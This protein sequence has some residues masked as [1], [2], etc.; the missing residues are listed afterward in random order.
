MTEEKVKPKKSDRYELTQVPTEMGV[1]FRD[2]EQ[3][4]DLQP[5]ELTLQMANDI[6]ELKKHLIG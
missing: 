3:E 2:T 6:A 1:A 4:K 5:V